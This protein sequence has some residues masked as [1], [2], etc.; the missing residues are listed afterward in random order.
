MDYSMLRR[1]ARENLAGMWP[2]AIAVAAVA[3]LVG[4]IGIRFLPDIDYWLTD[5]EIFH[6][7]ENFR[8]TWEGG[9]FGTFAFLLGGTLEL[10]YC[11][12]LLKQHDKRSPEFNDLFSQFH[13]F[14]TGFAQS[15]LRGLYC[16][17]WGLLF[18]IPGIVKDYA[19]AM[20]PYI[21]T[22]FPD[23]TAGQA[24]E[25]SKLMMDGHKGE[26]F[27]L[28]LTFIG[29]SILAGLCWNL[30]HLFLNPYRQAARAAFYRQLQE[31]ERAQRTTYTEYI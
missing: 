16:L 3:T 19:Y 6:I 5:R 30:G 21:L 9:I 12:F 14:G 31:Q 11:Q 26:L 17:L 18:I 23:M 13:R 10:G 8:V 4:G 20:T 7:G 28:E 27:V 1:R 15:F 29:W 2:L 22:D 25:R 24:I